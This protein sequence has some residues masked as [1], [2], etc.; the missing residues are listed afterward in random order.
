VGLAVLVERHPPQPEVIRAAVKAVLGQPEYRSRAQEFQRAIQK[1]PSLA[2][3]V[4]CLELLAET[5]QPQFSDS[6]Q[7]ENARA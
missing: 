1:L 3:A 2:E 7:D 4:R 6:H 5:Q